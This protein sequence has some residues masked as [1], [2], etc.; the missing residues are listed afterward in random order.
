MKEKQ[1]DIESSSAGA[2]AETDPYMVIAAMILGRLWAECSDEYLKQAKQA[3][4]D[5]L[6]KVTCANFLGWFIFRFYKHHK[7]LQYLSL[8]ICAAG[9]QRHTEA[10]S[11]ATGSR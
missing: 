6:P 4:L 11:H 10:A 1:K 3:A 2:I 5:V 9:A 8:T 7:A